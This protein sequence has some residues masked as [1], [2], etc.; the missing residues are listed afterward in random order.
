MRKNFDLKEAAEIAM[1]E[2]WFCK[3]PF[4][5]VSIEMGDSI[6]DVEEICASCTLP[7]R[8]KT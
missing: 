1:S 8:R 2:K 3:H 7:V 6:S 5:G 4:H